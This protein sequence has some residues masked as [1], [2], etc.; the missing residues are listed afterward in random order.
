MSTSGDILTNLIFLKPDE[1]YQ[2]EKP[3]RLRYDPGGTIPRTNCETQVQKDVLV[4]DIRGTESKYTLDRNG[5]QVLKVESRLTP[6]EFHDREKVKSVYY[7]EL[8]QLLK[9]TFGAKRV[10]ILEHGVGSVTL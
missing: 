8:G 6:E 9:R 3:Y 10:E 4:H 5:F 2:Y 7:E 1:K